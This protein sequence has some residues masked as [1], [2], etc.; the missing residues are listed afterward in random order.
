MK[1]VFITG[2]TGFVGCRLLKLLEGS[3]YKIQVLS[4]KQ[5]PVYKT[6]ICNLEKEQIPI[7]SLESVDTVFFV[8]VYAHS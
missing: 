8:A 2:A 1:E 6:T 7:S 4:R 5:H 3:G